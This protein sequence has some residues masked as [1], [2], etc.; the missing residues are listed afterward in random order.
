MKKI[1]LC[2]LLISSGLTYSQ[3]QSPYNPMP[4]NNA[5]DVS[6][7]GDISFTGGSAINATVD[8]S[9]RIYLDTNSNPT[10]VYTNTS[11][12]SFD[13]LFGNTSV[14]FSYNSLLE[15]TTYYWK[16]EVLDSSGNL[17]VTSPT[18][19]FTTIDMSGTGIFNGDALLETQTEVDNFNF[20][21]V[22]GQL[23]ISESS[24][25]AI[26]NL[27]G[28]TNLT[29]VGNGLAI[30]GNNN[31]TSLLGLEN[32]T[33]IQGSFDNLGEGIGLQIS[34]NNSLTSIAA[35]SNLSLL[36]GNLNIFS[37]NSLSSLQ[38]LEGITSING[39]ININTNNQITSLVGLN[40]LTSVNGVGFFG[41]GINIANNDSLTTL[42]GLSS[43]V[44][45]N[46]NLAII[47]NN[48]ITSLIG[49]ETL[50]TL[51]GTGN[52]T[53]E[54]ND[55][56]LTFNGLNN[57]NTLNGN[58]RIYDNDSLLSLDLLNLQVI[59]GGLE[60]TFNDALLK[61]QGLDNITSI[62]GYFWIKSN[63]NLTS[64][65]GL[66]NLITI[67]S[68]FEIGNVIN[69]LT[70]EI[71]SGN[72][73]LTSISNLSNLASIGENDPGAILT[74]TGCSSLTNLN[75]LENLNT[76]QQLFYYSPYN[77]IQIGSNSTNPNIFPISNLYN[78]VLTDFCGLQRFINYGELTSDSEII[79]ANNGSNPTITD[80]QN[81]SCTLPP[82]TQTAFKF[83]TAVNN[84][85]SIT[86]TIN[87]VTVTFTGN[88]LSITDVSQF[89]AGGYIGGGYDNVISAD[90]NSGVTFSFSEAVD[91]VSVMCSRSNFN[92]THT[93]TPTG[94]NNSVVSTTQPYASKVDLK[95]E[96][97]TS[98]TVTSSN[99]FYGFDDLRVYNNSTLSTDDLVLDNIKIYP[100]PTTDVINIKTD[101]P[102]TN[103]E[104]Y[105]LQGQKVNTS[106]SNNTVDVQNIAS[107]IYFLKLRTSKGE[108]TK[109]VIKN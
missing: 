55:S 26:T 50:I 65:E 81:L 40:N 61:L 66:D 25:G 100:N 6:L 71:Y 5:I 73:A 3:V 74:I 21:E 104:L 41:G 10:I 17:L 27:N 4:T 106:F 36:D 95:W 49:L 89:I 105:S 15:N 60:V 86:E 57:L 28:L 46:G 30:D 51:S 69:G 96:G 107:G 62:G 85:T 63:L 44:S 91:I 23:I 48:L 43:L 58:L 80:I 83:R 94:G 19:S 11:L 47:N 37:N 84:G 78:P 38:G 45:I 33:S 9:Y 18:W 1:L 29:T 7:L 56:L 59:G 31:L 82:A 77:K 79:I 22:T 54:D 72:I 53:I 52:L 87:G 24:N 98:F 2:L 76:L 34:N 75:G 13:F 97:V 99:G 16:V 103:A 32:I 14:E 102:I 90:T 93:F 108:V 12:G 8:M 101:D 67:G 64:L 88:N 92:V 20:T 70:G 39:N 42:N 68:D 35:L 109:K